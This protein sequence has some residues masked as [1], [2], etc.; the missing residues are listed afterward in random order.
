MP[1]LYPSEL[2]V[3]GVGREGN[4][5][6]YGET[7]EKHRKAIQPRRNFRMTCYSAF[8]DLINKTKSLKWSDFELNYCKKKWRAERDT[9][10]IHPIKYQIY[11]KVHRIQNLTSKL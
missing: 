7:N 9:S 11:I 6:N 2:W 5:G 4:S 8:N 1:W 3:W 10:N